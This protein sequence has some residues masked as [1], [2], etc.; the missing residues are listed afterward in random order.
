MGYWGSPDG[1]AIWDVG[2]NSP[3][4]DQIRLSVSNNE[5]G[6]KL[7]IEIGRKSSTVEVPETD[8][9]DSYKSVETG[10]IT[11]SNTGQTTLRVPVTDKGTWRPT[12]IRSVK[13]L[14]S[15]H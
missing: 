10:K 15:N 3:A 2:I 13:M 9:H 5:P 1:S 6:A 14:P 11:F 4:T 7:L 12:N 8:N